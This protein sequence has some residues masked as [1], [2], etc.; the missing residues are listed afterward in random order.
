MVLMT[1]WKTRGLCITTIFTSCSVPTSGSQHALSVPVH[2]SPSTIFNAY[3]STGVYMNGCLVNDTNDCSWACTR[4][5]EVFANIFTFQNCFHYPNISIRI[6]ENSVQNQ[7]LDTLKAW[8]F[9]GDNETIANVTNTL[10]ACYIA[11]YNERH[12]SKKIDADSDIGFPDICRDIN[13]FVNP[14]VGGSGVNFPLSSW[15]CYT[16]KSYRMQIYIS[17]WMQSGIA[18][19]GA[20][21]LEMT[22]SWIYWLFKIPLLLRDQHKQTARDRAHFYQDWLRV[23]HFPVVIAALVEFQKVQCYFLLAVMIAAL[24]V[25]KTGT[26]LVSNLQQISNN[27]SLMN[28]IATSGSLPVTFILFCLHCHGKRSWYL[29]TLSACTSIFAAATGIITRSLSPSMA[30]IGILSSIRSDIAQC[31]YFSPMA[32]CYDPNTANRSFNGISNDAFSI[33]SLLILLFLLIDQYLEHNRLSE[34]ETSQNNPEQASQR[35]DIPFFSQLLHDKRHLVISNP[36]SRLLF[37]GFL[38]IIWC[39]YLVWFA[40]SLQALWRF[41]KPADPDREVPLIN[42][43][44]WTFGQIV[45]IAIWAQPLIEY[46]YFTLRTISPELGF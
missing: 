40:F 38:S 25:L 8:K 11:A 41:Y 44:Q 30:E 31:G 39:I 42:M 27:Y 2:T 18:L 29:L 5:A 34:H 24:V 26:L 19:A 43:S 3:S 10:N 22:S 12:K 20:F 15:H 37:Q 17:Y 28:L 7:T 14:D 36:Q 46:F 23:K 1:R 35:F 45:A 13:S 6:R 32:Y 4:P 9:N 21:L 16:T 33:F